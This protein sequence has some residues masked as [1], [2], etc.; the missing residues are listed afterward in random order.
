MWNVMRPFKKREWKKWTWILIGCVFE[1]D[2]KFSETHHEPSIKRIKDILP[3][4]FPSPVEI[5][6][7]RWIFF[8][9]LFLNLSFF[10]SVLHDTFWF[11]ERSEFWSFFFLLGMLEWITYS[12]AEVKATVWINHKKKEVKCCRLFFFNKRVLMDISASTRHVVGNG[13]HYNGWLWSW[14]VCWRGKTLCEMWGRERERW[15]FFYGNARSTF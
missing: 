15:S 6:L 5:V 9:W 1:R 13:F 7:S 2:G 10:Y 8:K 3:L 14:H 11:H 4:F 12:L